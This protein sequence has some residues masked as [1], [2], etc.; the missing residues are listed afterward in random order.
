MG[1]KWKGIGRKGMLSIAHSEVMRREVFG[2][3]IVETSHS[4]K[5]LTP[6]PETFDTNCY[7][8]RSGLDPTMT[9]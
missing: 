3:A 9:S 5:Y 7:G 4:R 6:H 1:G 2:M 8:G